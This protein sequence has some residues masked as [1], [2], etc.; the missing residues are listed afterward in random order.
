VSAPMLFGFASMFE[1]DIVIHTVDARNIH[2]IHRGLPLG[3]TWSFSVKP[4][5]DRAIAN[6]EHSLV[7]CLCEKKAM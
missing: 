3:L 6:A 5:T 7:R 2:A 4:A 1:Q